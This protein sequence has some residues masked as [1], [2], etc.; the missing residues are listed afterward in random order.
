MEL[1]KEKTGY[2]DPPSTGLRPVATRNRASGTLKDE[3]I[4]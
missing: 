4:W 2:R 3:A 1:G